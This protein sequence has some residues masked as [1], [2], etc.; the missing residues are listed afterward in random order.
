MPHRPL[1]VVKGLN[2]SVIEEMFYLLILQKEL[3]NLHDKGSFIGE[4]EMQT[5]RTRIFI[6][7]IRLFVISEVY[8][9]TV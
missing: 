7:Y 3:K 6:Q 2:G 5:V 1:I 4:V 8:F 9:I